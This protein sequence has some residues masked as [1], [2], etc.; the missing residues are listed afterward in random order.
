MPRDQLSNEL[1]AKCEQLLAL[2]GS[3]ENC[4]IAFSGGLDSGVL[5]AAAHQALG[6]RAVAVT[7]T[8]PSMPEGELDEARRLA[9][10]IGIRHEVIAT[11]ELDDPN[12]RTNTPLRC[13]H[14][15]KIVL[16]EIQQLAAR[17]GL[18]V[19]LDGANRDDQADYRPGSRAAKEAGVRS[20]L[21]EC[22]LDKEELR[23]LA[24]HWG[25]PVWNKP[26]SPCLSSRIAYGQAIMLERLAMVDTAERFLREHG[27]V[28]VRVRYHEGELARI[29][30]PRDQMARL[31]D[32]PL[33]DEL[34][35]RLKT[36]GFAFVTLDLEGFR[37]GSLNAVLSDEDLETGGSLA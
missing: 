27:F 29:E 18:A 22:N 32:V 24:A 4:A 13:Y 12:Y 11:H 5:A 31:L 25:L 23:R 34:A 19:M 3:F 26:S 35:A 28:Q 20:P 21:A 30:V 8:S 14:C 2:L 7:A 17:L 37:S 1:R 15:R 6:D 16:A 36:L 10:Q 9:K 33:R